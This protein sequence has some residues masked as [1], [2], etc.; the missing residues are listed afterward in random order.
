MAN[1]AN[2]VFVS[3]CTSTWSTSTGAAART[4]AAQEDILYSTALYYIF[5][6][7]GAGKIWDNINT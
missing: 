4:L 1:C 2:F 3:A 5:S 6:I 7:H